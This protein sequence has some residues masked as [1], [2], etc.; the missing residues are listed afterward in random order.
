MFHNHKKLAQCTGCDG[1]IETP[2]SPALTFDLC[3]VCNGDGTT[4]I[5]CDGSMSFGRNYDICG[6]CGG[7]GSS[8]A[9]INSFIFKK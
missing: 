6:V 9:S 7:D 5:G 2:T 1:L 4:C 3:G 8:C